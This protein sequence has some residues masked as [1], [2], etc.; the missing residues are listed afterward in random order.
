MPNR[1]VA[2]VRPPT[3]AVSV[4]E[5]GEMVAEPAHIRQAVEC[6][7]F[8]IHGEKQRPTSEFARS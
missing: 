8:L 5:T 1:P 4:A 3:A 6:K 7:V 2:F